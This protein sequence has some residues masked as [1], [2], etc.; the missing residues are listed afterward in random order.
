MEQPPEEGVQG[1]EQHNGMHRWER[2]LGKNKSKGDED[3]KKILYNV[4]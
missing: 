2:H 3:P 1:G 4:S